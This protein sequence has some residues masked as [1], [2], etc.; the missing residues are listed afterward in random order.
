MRGAVDH[1]TVSL[2]FHSKRRP[3]EGSLGQCNRD[4]NLRWNRSC[5]K[6]PYNQGFSEKICSSMLDLD[7]GSFQRLTLEVDFGVSYT[8]SPVGYGVCDLR[9]RKMKLVGS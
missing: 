6:K 4:R 9:V 3:T 2:F 8:Q 5:A 1:T 7:L